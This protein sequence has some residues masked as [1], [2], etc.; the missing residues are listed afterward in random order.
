MAYSL[1]VRFFLKALE[2]F[3]RTL[4]HTVH[5]C[6]A[7]AFRKDAGRTVPPIRDPILLKSA[8]QLAEEIRTRKVKSQDV[9]LAYLRR[10]EEVDPLIN[11]TVERRRAAALREAE[12]VDALVE[13]GAMTREQMARERPLLGVP[14]TVK[15]LLS[16]KGMRSTA[17]SLLFRD[18]L[19][20]EDAPTVSLMRRAGAIVVATTNTAEMG[21]HFETNNYAHGRTANPYDLARTSGGSSGGESA[22]ISAGGSLLGLG[23]DMAGSIRLPCMFTGLFG[24]KPSKGLVTSHGSFPAPISE[25]EKFLFTGPMCRYSMDLQLAMSVLTSQNKNPLKFGQRVNFKDLKVYYMTSVGYHPLI[26]PIDTETALAIKKAVSHFESTYGIKA[27]EVKIPNLKSA[28][29]IYIH[30]LMSSCKDIGHALTSGK[31]DITPFKEFLKHLLGRSTLTQGPIIV[32]NSPYFPLLYNEDDVVYYE[33]LGKKLAGEFRQLLD[34]KSVLLFPTFPLQAPYHHEITMLLPSTC[35]TL[36]YN[37]LGLPVTQC[38]MGLRAD[39]LPVGL[40]I[41]GGMNNDPLTIACAA[42]LEKA[43]GGWIPPGRTRK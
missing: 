30:N 19:A 37:L 35:Y 1:A 29:A 31:G 27:K 39:G 33:K 6:L 8:A 11:A 34:D 5:S 16:V 21:M 36:V 26:T 7:I 43:F 15:V 2:Y 32:M 42:E 41:V 4:R 24:H 10:I 28:A 40:Q 3:Y 14:L 38:P 22:L 18:A 9:V 13:S 17:G 20:A 12:E 23:N 25:L